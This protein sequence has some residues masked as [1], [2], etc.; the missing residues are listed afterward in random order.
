[1]DIT[2]W[3]L[4]WIEPFG[5]RILEPVTAFTDLITASICFYAFWYLSRLKRPQALHQFFR[6]YFL[7]MGCATVFAGLIGHAFLHFLT[8]SWKMIGWTCSSLAIYMIER[9]T[10]EV[11]K[12]HLGPRITRVMKGLVLLQWLIFFSCILY[13]DP[14]T[15]GFHMVKI[16]STIGLVGVVLPLQFWHWMLTRDKGSQWVVTSI[17]CSLLPAITYNFEISLA[18]WFNYHDVSHVLMAGCTFLMFVGAFHLKQETTPGAFN[19]FGLRTDN[20]QHSQ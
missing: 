9:S 6:A 15:R 5:L 18:T 2:P 19:P 20:Y 14:A 12:T 11:M 4:T 17:V 10:L 3:E 7:F 8:P 16:N 13:P 1:M